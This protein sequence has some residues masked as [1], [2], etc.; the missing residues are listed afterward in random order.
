VEHIN[1]H[2]VLTTTSIRA[3]LS[4]YGYTFVIAGLLLGVAKRV[5][6]RH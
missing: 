1:L 3:T 4:I 5:F 6:R 2:E